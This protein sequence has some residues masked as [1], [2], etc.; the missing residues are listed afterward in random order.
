[1]SKEKLGF[2]LPT[3]EE[4]I[5]SNPLTISPEAL[6]I[7]AIARLNQPHSLA[8]SSDR[9]PGMGISRFSYLLILENTKLV[10]VLTERDIVKLSAANADLK[11]LT[12][13]EVMSR[14]VV[15]FKESDFQDIYQIMSIL[16]QHKIRHLPVV[17]DS[18]QLTGMI[19]SE[20][21][22]RALNPTNLLKM[23]TVEEVMNKAVLQASPTT[24]ILSLSQLMAE[25]NQ[26]CVVIVERQLLPLEG[27]ESQ[28]CQSEQ[29]EKYL[30]LG[31]PI[32]IITERD[33]VQF[34]ILGLDLLHTPAREVMST[35]LI[36]MK[37]TDSLLAVQQ[38]MIKLR[39][40][41]LVVTGKSGK[42]IG[43]IG[44]QDMLRVFNTTELYSVISTLKQELNQQTQHLQLEIQQ[45]E[46]SEVM[47][48]NNQHLL[49]LFVRRAP[50]AIAMLDRE[51]RYIV[52]S[53]RW[54]Q[55]YQLKNKNIVGLSH[56]EVF[57]ELPE[58]W[59]QDHQDI[60]TGRV[61][62]LKSEEDSFVRSDG[63]VD[64]LRWEL[65][66]WHDLEGKIGGLLMLCEVITERKLLEQKL[67]SSEAQIRAMF[68]AMTDLVLTIDSAD[69]SIQILPT[70]LSNSSY[71]IDYERAIEQT[72]T[73]LFDGAEA[74]KYQNVI[75]EVLQSQQTINLEY[76]FEVDDCPIWFSVNISPVSATMVI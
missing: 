51:V 19:A 21:I 24:S 29:T 71:A 1:M 76:S 47:L 62:F 32:G 22:S 55:D 61:E 23:R 4:V 45:R 59:K 39:V 65:M 5:E 9:T 37:P 43:I 25:H 26:S 42:L 69:N 35:P 41:R 73:K 66:P 58:R 70:N 13:G 8:L 31:T 28:T 44:F 6:V 63:R 74:E 15:T 52:A 75:Q 40:R 72:L 48:R 34:Q 60:L 67:H 68:E 49:E 30:Y 54:I 57:P 11:S 14:N 36:C 38:Q 56:Y 33:I 12:V 50:A 53:D 2:K 27:A 16:R 7:D 3:L 46:Q 64:W 18:G 17:D 10:G 20:N